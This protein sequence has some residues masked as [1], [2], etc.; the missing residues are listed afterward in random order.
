MKTIRDAEL[1]LDSDPLAARLSRVAIGPM[2][3][4]L[5]ARVLAGIH[6]RS[7]EPRHRRLFGRLA[8]AVRRA[9]TG[10]DA[11]GRRDPSTGEV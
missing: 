3:P 1:I 4:D 8:G 11:R 6:P 10:V 5:L 2:S 7:P 9:V